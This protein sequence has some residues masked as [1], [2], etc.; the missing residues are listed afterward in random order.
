MLLLLSFG[1]FFG[2]FNG[3]SVVLSYLIKPWFGEKDLPFAVAAVGGSPVVSGIIGVVILGTQQ[4]KSKQF[5][6]WVLIC[7]SGKTVM[8]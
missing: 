5:K 8:I 7:M 4:R 6:K 3:I 2:I 1:C